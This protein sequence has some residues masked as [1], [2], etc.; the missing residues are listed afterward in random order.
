MIKLYDISTWINV[1]SM[2]YISY[3]Y[4][5]LLSLVV[6]SS[7]VVHSSLVVYSSLQ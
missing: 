6:Y 2:Q 4:M 7:L 3:D 1:L 5:Y